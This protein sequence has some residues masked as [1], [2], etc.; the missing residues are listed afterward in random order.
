MYIAQENRSTILDD[1]GKANFRLEKYTVDRTLVAVRK[2]LAALDAPAYD[3]GVLSE[4]GMLPGLSNLPAESVLSRLPLLKAHNARGAH[5]YIR[6]SGEHRFTVLDDLDRDSGDRLSADGY[7]PC[8]L[9]ETSRGNFQAWLKHDDV[10]PAPLST[11]IAR[12]LAERYGADPSAADWRRFGR[13]PGFTNC[14]PKYLR[15][16]GLYPYVLLRSATGAEYRRSTYLRLEM[17][18]LYQ[19]EEQER[20]A[21][22]ARRRSNSAACSTGAAYSWLSLERFRNAAKFHDHPAAADIAFCVA[23]SSLRMPEDAIAATLDNLYLSQ[24]PNPSKKA[25]YIRRTMAKARAWALK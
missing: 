25:A 2:M 22:A 6:A 9:V 20:E 1:F 3:I 21:Q 5:I 10:Y 24:D 14:K 23:A 4:R 12:T 13:L 8:A 18:K 7:E 11:L 15:S 17:T 16:D 19:L